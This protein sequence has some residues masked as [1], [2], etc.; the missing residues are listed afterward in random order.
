MSSREPIPINYLIFDDD[1]DAENQ[2]NTRIKISG[3]IIN[4]IFINPKDYFDAE[5]NQFNK[6]LF[7][8]EIIEKTKGIN[9][10][11]VITDWNIIPPTPNTEFQGIVG[12]HIIDYI[13]QAKEKLKSRQFL[14][15]SSD[16]NR[17]SRYILDNIKSEMD[18]QKDDIESLQFISRILELRLKFCKRDEQRFEEIITLLK[19]S[20]T[21]S[22]MVLN[23]ILSFD[24][25]MVI[26]TG[27]EDFDGRKIGDLLTGPNPDIKGL[28]FIR[29][30]IELAIAHYTKLNA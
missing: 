11:L 28:K 10:N 18:S 30:M 7:V 9:I 26:E 8:E 29:E 20:N 14:V 16:I 3:Y 22:N 25:T 15:Y 13:L 17:A 24:E 4:S 1:P 23:S 21:I 6:S 5:S 12:W 27:N 2:Y 19:E